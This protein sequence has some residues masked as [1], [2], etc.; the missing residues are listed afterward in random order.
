MRRRAVGQQAGREQAERD[1][2][3]RRADG[4]NFPARAD[5]FLGALPSFRDEANALASDIQD[6]ADDAAASAASA[7]GAPGTSA[8]FSRTLGASIPNSLDTGTS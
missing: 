2:G 1:D 4:A 6:A 8:T 5:A 3:G 7:L